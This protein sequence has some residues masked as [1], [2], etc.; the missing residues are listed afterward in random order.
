MLTAITK[1]RLSFWSLA[2]AS[3]LSCFSCLASAEGMDLKQVLASRQVDEKQMEASRGGME[4]NG[5]N[6]DLGIQR[7][8]MINGAIQSISQLQWNSSNQAAAISNLN[9]IAI[10]NTLNNQVIKLQTTINANV[11][12][13]N[14]FRQMLSNELI[15]QSLIRGLH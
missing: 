4:I 13:L 14:M 7:T 9:P 3:G 15:T 6:I 12:N 10:S 5:L 11:A 2:L 8:V 1:Y